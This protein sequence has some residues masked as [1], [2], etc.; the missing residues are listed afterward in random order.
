MSVRGGGGIDENV[1]SKKCHTQ[2]VAR[3]VHKIEVGTGELQLGTRLSS[4][5][6]VIQTEQCCNGHTN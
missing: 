5:V 3:Q 1:W 2:E 6:L 4:A